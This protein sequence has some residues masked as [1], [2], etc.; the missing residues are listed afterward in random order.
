MRLFVRHVP[1]NIRYS[2][3]TKSSFGTL[4]YIPENVSEFRTV[5][6]VVLSVDIVEDPSAE[7]RDDLRREEFDCAVIRVVGCHGDG[8]VAGSVV[9][10]SVWVQLRPAE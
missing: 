10:L 4:L 8:L 2:N 1:K 6:P 3:K 9:D 7:F 5:L